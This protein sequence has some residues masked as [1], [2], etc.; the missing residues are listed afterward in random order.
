MARILAL[1]ACTACL[2]FLIKPGSESLCPDQSDLISGFPKI[3]SH[4]L[5]APKIANVASPSY[6]LV[7]K[8][9][10]PIQL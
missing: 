8:L 9:Y 4:Q 5:K 10:K 2:F 3:P 7:Y 6:Q 1:T